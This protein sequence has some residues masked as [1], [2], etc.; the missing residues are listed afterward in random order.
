MRHYVFL[1]NFIEKERTQAIA[2]KNDM[3]KKPWTWHFVS[4]KTEQISTY[5][6]FYTKTRDV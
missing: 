5:G 3:Q 6:E 4:Y 2:K 1:S